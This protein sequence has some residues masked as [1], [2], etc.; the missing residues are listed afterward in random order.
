VGYSIN[1]AL[2][3]ALCQETAVGVYFYFLVIAGE[4]LFSLQLDDPLRP[5]AKTE[6]KKELK[7]CLSARNKTQTNRQ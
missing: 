6:P 3:R 2:K 5:G 7:S 4:L 1:L